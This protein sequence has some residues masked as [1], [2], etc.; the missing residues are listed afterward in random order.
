MGIQIWI[1]SSAAA[2]CVCRTLVMA[3]R[4]LAY[5][6]ASALNKGLKSTWRG[7]EYGCRLIDATL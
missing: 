7:F 1:G 3:L 4:K 6:I 2:L 5:H